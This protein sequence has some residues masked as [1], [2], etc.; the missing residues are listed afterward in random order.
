MLTIADDATALAL[1]GVSIQLDIYL[2]R[3]GETLT[4]VVDANSSIESVKHQI[5][6]HEAVEVA[7]Q[8]LTFGSK[9]LEDHRSLSDYCI[10]TGTTLTMWIVG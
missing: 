4:L 10:G 1:S 5:A 2:R 6:Q 8:R 3:R 7:D 9:L